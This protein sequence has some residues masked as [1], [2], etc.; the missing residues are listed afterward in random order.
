MDAAIAKVRA[1]EI[2][3][4]WSDAGVMAGDPGWAGGT[5]FVD[6]REVM[7]TASMASLWTAVSAL[8]GERGYY[9]VDWLWWLRGLMDRLVGGPGVQH[10]AYRGGSYP[11]VG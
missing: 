4:A 2:E 10:L 9:A 3:T 6:R 7:T 1:G 5:L 8:G 11:V